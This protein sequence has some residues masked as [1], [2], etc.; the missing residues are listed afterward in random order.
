LDPGGYLELVVTEA[1]LTKETL[2]A[3]HHMAERTAL[4]VLVAIS[5]CHLMN[6][7]MQSLLAA[8]YPMLKASYS[9]DFGQIGL[10]TLVFQVTASLLQ[11]LVGLF[12][13][14]RPQTYA[15]CVGMS[16]TLCGLLLL[17]LAGSYPLLLLAAALI[18]T[19][20]SV[21][22]PESSRVARAASGG[23]HGLA[24]SVF[25]VGGNIGT[26][27]GPLAAAF[28]I[29][30]RGQTSVA[31]FCFG[32]ML[33][34]MVLARVSAWHKNHRRERAASRATVHLHRPDL[35]RRQIG[36]AITVLLLLI[37]S[38]YFYVASLSNYLTFYLISKF[39]ISVKA[40]QLYLFAFLG[41][42]A[43]GTI[44]GGPLGDRIGRKWVIWASI[45]GALPFTLMLPYVD[46]FWTCILSV[47]VGL[48][49]SSAFSAILVYAQ[50]LVPGRVGMIAGLFFGFAF[51]MGG[52]GAA[53]LGELADQTSIDFVYRICAFLPALGIVTVLLPNIET[54]FARRR[55]RQPV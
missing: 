33:G 38:K 15:L 6:D 55:K 13:D 2:A 27:V 53:V 34:I 17:A 3:G 8:L 39:S 44:V 43:L 11:P 41:A 48:I 40:A 16:F 47:V 45:L 19:G 24:Q 1:A 32:A 37:F 9:L 46:L 26:A 51:G 20:S 49:I 29:L 14:R 5:F 52:I 50:E 54:E 7:M 22:H 30:P 31:W 21:F 25:Q 35:S 4:L 28:I 23:R 42:S 36:I 18:G 10:I 12:T